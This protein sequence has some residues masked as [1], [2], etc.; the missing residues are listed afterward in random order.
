M[1][2]TQLTLNTRPR[3]V[4]AADIIEAYKQTGSVWQAGKLIGLS[5][6]NVHARLQAIGY[7]LAGRHWT[8][9]ECDELR[10]LIS[11]GVTLGEVANRLGRPYAGVAGKASEL[12][13]RSRQVREKKLP[14]GG[15]WDKATTLRHM[16][17]IEAYDGK[18]TQYARANGLAI[19]LL[20]KALQKHCMD[21]WQ[22]Y[23]AARSDLPRRTCAY[24]EEP[25]IPMS[26]KQVYCDRKCA[27]DA[28]QDASYFGGKRKT[29]I[30]LAQ[31]VCQLC[32]RQ[33][34]RGLSS[35]HVLGKD[36]DPENDVL[37]ALCQGCH[38]I[39]TFLGSRT[40]VDDEV[41]WESLI[42][43][44][45]MRRHGPDLAAGKFPDGSV[46][47]VTVELETYVDEYADEAAS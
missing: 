18:V 5:G 44:A 9:Q 19:E 2:D 37:V 32:G 42:S 35:H 22:A 10:A 20:V 27:A 3:R 36:N 7:P 26:G 43:L 23:V 12:G 47:H 21:R 41:A 29:T 30:G 28:R 8:E 46:L 25:F 11:Q 6:Q 14:R 45:W 33:G 4:P 38:K 16:K 1:P 31:G 15:G 40:F 34:I 24:C 39:I 17:A 13:I